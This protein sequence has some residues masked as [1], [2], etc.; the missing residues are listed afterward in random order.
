MA[1]VAQRPPGQQVPPEV[2]ERDEAPG[3]EALRNILRVVLVLSLAATAVLAV[4]PV[5]GMLLL[6]AMF[7]GLAYVG[8]MIVSR[9]ERQRWKARHPEPRSREVGFRVVTGGASSQQVERSDATAEQEL[10]PPPARVAGAMSAPYAPRPAHESDDGGTEEMFTSP[11]RAG[12]TAALK[13]ATVIVVM[14]AAV[15]AAVFD[16]R[17]LG[18]GAV[19]AVAYMA[20]FGMPVWVASVEQAAEEEKERRLAGGRPGY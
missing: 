3:Y 19:L 11:Q 9:L 4:F 14:A 10:G 18:V 8:L 16:W 20:L 6:P 7:A 13:I 17:L 5:F 15:A 12:A 1:S 2:E